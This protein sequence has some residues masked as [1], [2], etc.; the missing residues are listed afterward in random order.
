MTLDSVDPADSA[1]PQEPAESV[2]RRSDRRRAIGRFVA[3]CAIGLAALALVGSAIVIA[4]EQRRQTD[5]L[6]DQSCYARATALAQVAL[7]DIADKAST[8]ADPALLILTCDEVSGV[9]P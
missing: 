3:S 1:E 5:V 9:S 2:S 4:V 6:R 7:V 8:S